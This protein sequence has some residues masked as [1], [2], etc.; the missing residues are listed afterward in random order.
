MSKE[1]RKRKTFQLRL[2]KFELLHLRDLFGVLLSTE[3]KQTV[4]QALAAA[5]ERSLIEARLWQRIAAACVEAD[6]PTDEEA[7]DFICAAM[8]T[9]PPVGVFRLAQE[10]D[11]TPSKPTAA[12]P[13]GSDEESE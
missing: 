7:P 8:V 9:P 3:A 10:P 13:F 6:L 2:S 1:I 5:E 11:E 12:H 4:S